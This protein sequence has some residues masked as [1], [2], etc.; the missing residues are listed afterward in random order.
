[1]GGFTLLFHALRRWSDL[2]INDLSAAESK[3]TKVRASFNL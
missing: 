2:E 1:V 3:H